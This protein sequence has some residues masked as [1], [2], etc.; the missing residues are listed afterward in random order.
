MGDPETK[1]SR[2]HPELLNVKIVQWPTTTTTT[3]CLVWVTMY[4]IQNLKFVFENE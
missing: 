4:V 1:S 2:T 3:R